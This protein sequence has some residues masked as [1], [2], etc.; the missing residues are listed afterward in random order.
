MAA[1]LHQLTARTAGE[2]ILAG[3]G[4][5]GARRAWR[6]AMIATLWW[7]LIASLGRLTATP[8]T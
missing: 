2:D 1:W 6:K 5:R 4:E 7:R 8:G 3:H